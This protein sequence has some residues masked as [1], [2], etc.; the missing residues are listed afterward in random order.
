[1]NYAMLQPGPVTLYAQVASILRDRIV[2]GKWK[3]GEDIP[4]LDEL[5]KQL[6]VARITVRQAI[7]MLSSEGLLSSQRGRRS[8]VTYDLID[9]DQRPLFSS[10]G[11]VDNESSDYGVEILSREKVSTLPPRQ[12]SAGISASEYVR[13]RKIDSESSIPYVVSENYVAGTVARRFPKGSERKQKISRLVRDYANP[14]IDKGT[15]VISVGMVTYEEATHL[16]AP[17]SSPVARVT[18][19]FLDADQQIIYYGSLVYRCE[20]FRIERDISE[21]LRR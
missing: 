19:L 13:I 21:F 14:P 15:E 17:L 4:T 1:V 18:R 6:S 16:H 12:V 8:I 9:F 10:V 11:S 7:Q 5:A 20:R 3:N 2:S